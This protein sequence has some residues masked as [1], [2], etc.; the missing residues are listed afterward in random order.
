MGKPIDI[1]SNKLRQIVPSVSNEEIQH[2]LQNINIQRLSTKTTIISEGERQK[3]IYFLVE[4]LVRGYYVNLN[5][6]IIHIRFI[7]N[8]GWVTHYSALLTGSTSKYT[9]ECLEESIVL[10]LPFENI[11]NGYTFSKNIIQLGRLIAEEVLIYQQKRIESFQFLNA[12]QRYLQFV[13]ENPDL[14]NRISLTH[15]SSFLGIQRQ[16]LTRIRHNLAKKGYF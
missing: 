13:E 12:E 15:L 11:Q 10:A 8:N 1:F 14:F 7:S 2:L 9:F 4:G 6:D 16:S 5:G 3:Y